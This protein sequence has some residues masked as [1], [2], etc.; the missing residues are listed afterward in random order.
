VVA[1]G[2]APSL[3]YQWQSSP[4]G[5]TWTNI[6]GAVSSTYTTP[7]LNTSTHY[8]VV[9]GASG[10]GCNSVNSNAAII[11]VVAQQIVN[12]SGN[13]TICSGGTATFTATVS[14]GSGTIT[15]Q[16]QDSPDGTTWTNISGAT[17]STFTTPALVEIPITG[18]W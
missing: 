9:V 1:S 17:S 3:T 6:S 12:I 8:R 7:V 14:G 4:D 10:S 2:G 15:Y 16:W 11:S 18:W 13:Q 5:T